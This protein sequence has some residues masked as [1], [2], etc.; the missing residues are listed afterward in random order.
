MACRRT[1][2]FQGG[3]KRVLEFIPETCCQLMYFDNPRMPYLIQL[4]ST[5]LQRPLCRRCS[6]SLCTYGYQTPIGSRVHCALRASCVSVAISQT[7][8][9]T[10]IP[11][12]VHHHHHHH[13]PSRRDPVITKLC[14]GGNLTIALQLLLSKWG[15]I[16]AVQN[17]APSIVN[18]AKQKLDPNLRLSIRRL[19]L[20]LLPHS[21]LFL[22][23]DTPSPDTPLSWTKSETT[24]DTAH[25]HLLPT[26]PCLHG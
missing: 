19:R 12:P 4:A 22:R 9:H 8:T 7:Q 17:T 10:H 5:F 14:F 16:E 3:I 20:R 24:T 6:G 11:V 25:R 1:R 21:K 18:S 2:S 15:R 23:T 26:R 13:H